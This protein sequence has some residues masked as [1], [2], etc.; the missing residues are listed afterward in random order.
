MITRGTHVH[1]K[2]EHRESVRE[3]LRT[4][5]SAG[6]T[7]C[8]PLRGPLGPRRH[9]GLRAPR[10]SSQQTRFVP[11]VWLASVEPTAGNRRRGLWGRKLLPVCSELLSVS[12][13]VKSEKETKEV[14]S[15]GYSALREP[16]RLRNAGGRPHAGRG[17]R[18]D[19]A[20]EGHAR[21][22]KQLRVATGL[23]RVWGG[24][25]FP[26]TSP[27]I[28]NEQAACFHVWSSAPNAL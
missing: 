11:R 13:Y 21:E 22:Q 1:G 26:K 8:S 7:Q 25:P 4:R 6:G 2:P 9:A 14:N 20:G 27:D 16:R 19:R 17:S 24:L 5:V 3:A 15:V 18:P 23:A 10:S 28:H 12:S